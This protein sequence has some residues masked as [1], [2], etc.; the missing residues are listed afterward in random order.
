MIPPKPAKAATSRR[1]LI[2]V[3]VVIT[4]LGTVIQAR[5]NGELV[6]ITDSAPEVGMWNI[7]S[8][9]A[10]AS[11]FVFALRNLRASWKQMTRALKSRQ[12]KIWEI[13]GG[14]G[15]IFFVTTQSACAPVIGVALFSVSVVA[16][17]TSSAVIVDRVGLGPAGRQPITLL[18][19]VAVVVAIIAV[20][21][22]VSDR[23]DPSH[24]SD[25]SRAFVYVALA[26]AVGVFSAAQSALNGRV[27][28]RSGHA[29]IAGWVNFAVGF[30][31]GMIGL[32]LFN[33]LGGHTLTGL[34]WDRPWLLV[35]GVL[36]LVYVSTA[37]WAVRP[38]GVLVT[39]ILSVVGLLLGAL[40]VD[41]VSPTAGTQF[42]W[43]LVA[44][45]IIALF[46]SGLATVGRTAR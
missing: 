19:I 39:A 17:Q 44:G 37:A 16:G 7:T 3:L 34:P 26:V 1:L 6:I 13:L 5:I 21:V 12:L 14:V 29:F 45:V 22:A 28:A 27:A 40:L 25:S 15:G 9:L 18:R 23:F 8:G 20:V 32:A 31:I 10:V 43:H 2:S 38:L 36:G 33:V 35:G 41:L 24:L 11:I 46:A 4:S 30:A 42:G